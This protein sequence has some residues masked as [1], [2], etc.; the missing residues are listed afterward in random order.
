MTFVAKGEEETLFQNMKE[1]IGITIDTLPGRDT[2]LKTGNIHNFLGIIII[3]GVIKNIQMKNVVLKLCNVAVFH[4][5]FMTNQDFYFHS[6][7]FFPLFFILSS[8]FSERNYW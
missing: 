7:L 3:S 4:C 1:S 2:F 6:F 8:L 5:S